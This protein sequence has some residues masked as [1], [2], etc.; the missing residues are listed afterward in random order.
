VPLMGRQR[1]VLGA[2][3][4][5]L[6][7]AIVLVEAPQ[8]APIVSLRATYDGTT[9]C[10]QGLDADGRARVFSAANFNLSFFDQ[11]NSG[12]GGTGYEEVKP[13]HF[14]G[15]SLCTSLTFGKRTAVRF[16]VKGLVEGVLMEAKS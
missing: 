4:A 13:E 9:A 6:F 2:A 16:E 12:L 1:V 11:N 8:Q 10:V 7:V 14:T 15:L 3:L 5:S